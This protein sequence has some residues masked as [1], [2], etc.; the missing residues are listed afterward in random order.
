[1]SSQT[2]FAVAAL[3]S[4]ALATLGLLA[5]LFAGDATR[6]SKNGFDKGTSSFPFK[7]R[8]AYKTKKKE[9]KAN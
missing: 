1:M 8:E 9:A 5:L 6:R 3:C 4:G 2:A 7:N